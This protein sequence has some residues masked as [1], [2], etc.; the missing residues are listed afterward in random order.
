MIGK[1]LRLNVRRLMYQSLI[2]F[3][4]ARDE[5]RRVGA[6]F[7]AQGLE[8]DAD[9]LIDGMRRDVE[10]GRDFLGREMLVHQQKTIELPASQL[11]EPHLYRP[12]PIVRI[13]RSRRSVH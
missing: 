8:R 3:V 9:A 7:H 2:W 1:R 11:R 12:L 6:T 10:L 5:A 4:V 13:A